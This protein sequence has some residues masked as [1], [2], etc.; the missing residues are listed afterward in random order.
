MAE[1]SE[2][3]RELFDSCLEEV[4]KDNLDFFD[5]KQIASIR[6]FAKKFFA[7]EMK[8]KPVNAEFRTLV[9]EISKSKSKDE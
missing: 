9:S 1:G 7:A 6:A 4:L 3:Q 2:V 5:Y 8:G